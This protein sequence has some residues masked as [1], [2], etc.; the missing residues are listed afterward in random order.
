[1]KDD[2]SDMTED[3]FDARWATGRRA[4]VARRSPKAIAN[5]RIYDGQGFH[6]TETRST[7]SGSHVAAAG[8]SSAGR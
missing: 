7:T 5:A 1:M 2:D 3:E 4:E 6:V 8:L